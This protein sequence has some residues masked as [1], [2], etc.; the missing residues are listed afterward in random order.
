VRRPTE[1][2]AGAGEDAASPALLIRDLVRRH[3]EREALD[4]VSVRLERGRT[5][6]VFGGNGA[7]KTTLLRVLATLLRPHAGQVEVLG[8]PLPR[9]SWKVR[10][11]IGY[12]GHESLLYPELSARENLRFHAGLHRV[13]PARVDDLLER[14]G[15]GHRADDPVRE[16]SRGMVQRVAAARA[17]LHRPELLLLDEP[18]AGL[19][20]GAVAL[21]EPLIGPAAGHARVLVTHDIEAGLAEADAVLGLRGGRMAFVGRA[22]PAQVRELYA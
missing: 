14:V 1:R 13:A 15:L 20:P 3:G 22:G 9:E 4:G 12:L 5:M 16:L 10:G 8:S 18:R 11:R 21:L 7:G 17:V 19:D 2:A 6:V